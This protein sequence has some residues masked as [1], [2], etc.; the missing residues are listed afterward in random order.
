MDTPQRVEVVPGNTERK[1]PD[2]EKSVKLYM[3]GQKQCGR[4]VFNP[5][6][7]SMRCGAEKLCLL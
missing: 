5:S 1:C 3:A 4:K 6:N 2:A 7:G